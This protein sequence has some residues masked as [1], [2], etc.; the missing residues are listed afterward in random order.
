[1]NSQIAERREKL[2][3]G[4]PLLFKDVQMSIGIGP[5]YQ[6]YTFGNC[7][8]T[9]ENCE[10]VEAAKQYTQAIIT[11]SEAQGLYLCGDVGTGKTLLAAAI[12]NQ[13]IFSHLVARAK[14]NDT[15]FI[16]YADGYRHSS[17]AQISPVRFFSTADLFQ[18]IRASFNFNYADC[19]VE[20]IPEDLVKVCKKVPVLVLDDF[21]AEKPTEWVQ[22]QFFSIIDHRYVHLLPL[23]L[24][25]NLSPQEV[26]QTYGPRISDRIRDYCRV[27]M[28]TGK[29]QRT[30]AE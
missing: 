30:T 16:S 7:D 21:G 5:R 29:S 17:P 18:R 24:T 26:E 14:H 11:N 2:K 6:A 1:M 10:A 8:V 13:L 3:K 22:E 12:A 20:N 27:E 9:A 25:S 28:L 23:I 19:D 15:I 4:F